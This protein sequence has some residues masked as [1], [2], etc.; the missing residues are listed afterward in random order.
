MTLFFEDSTRTRLSFETAA[1]RLSADTMTFTRG[2]LVGRARARA[3]ST[4]CRRSRRW[5]STRS[6]CATSAP[7]P[8]HRVAAGSTPRVVNAGDGRHEHPTQALLDLLTLR[9]HLGTDAL[10]R[11]A[12]R[13]SSATSRHSRVARSG[14][15]A[16]APIGAEVTAGR[17]AHPAARVARGL[18]GHAS[19]TTSTTCSPRSTSSTCC[20]SSASASGAAL[21]PVAARVHDA[22]TG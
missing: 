3:C 9:R 5:A 6:S 11:A 15:Q 4:P 7:A 8:P 19:P 2:E 21:L 1:K 18:A 14:V 12:G 17:T 20:A 16:L 10:R 22:A 13:R